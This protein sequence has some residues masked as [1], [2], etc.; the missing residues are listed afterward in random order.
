M[1]GAR[2]GIR[3][4]ESDHHGGAQ[5]PQLPG[6]RPHHHRGHHPRLPG[7][8][9]IGIKYLVITSLSRQSLRNLRMKS[10]DSLRILEDP[11]TKTWKLEAYLALPKLLT[12]FSNRLL[13][14]IPCCYEF[15]AINH[16]ICILCIPIILI[17]TILNVATSCILYIEI[18]INNGTLSTFIGKTDGDSQCC[19]TESPIR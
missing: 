1:C 13:I 7:E 3:G 8:S 15:L 14:L 16:Y 12:E 19:I 6:G 9:D 10:L 17:M 4:P 2:A 5:P 11:V 18:Q